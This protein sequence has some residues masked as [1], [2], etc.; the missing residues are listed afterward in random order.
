MTDPSR[1]MVLG[2]ALLVPL[3]GCASE[4]AGARP[5]PGRSSPPVPPSAT[6]PRH[7][8]APKAL[9]ALEREHDARL[10]VYALATGTGDLVTHRADERFAFCS[11]FKPLAVA[12]LLHRGPASVLDERIAVTAE[13]IDSIAP[14]T[15]ERVGSRMTVRELCDAAIRYSDGVAADLLVR[16]LGGP[17]A[18]TAYLRRLG[19]RVSRM[20]SYEPE[21][22]GNGPKDERDTTTPRAIAADY[23]ALVLGNALAVKQRALLLDWLERSTTGAERIRAGLPKGWRRL[24]HKTGTGNYGRANDIGIAWPGQGP[25]LLIAIMTD[26]DGY[27]AAPRERLIAEAAAYVARTLT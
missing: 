5:S 25:P 3:A 23:R 10:G 21:L 9:A 27:D 11:T 18:L 8:D 14:I 13:D 12:A 16:E 19:D 24:A 22:N 2:A 1:R 26:R 7:I 6:P 15:Q 17:G 20:D 4:A